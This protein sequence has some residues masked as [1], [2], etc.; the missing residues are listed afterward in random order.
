MREWKYI[1]LHI[2]NTDAHVVVAQPHVTAALSYEKNSLLSQDTRL[3]G[4]NTRS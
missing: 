4:H 1:S 2:L 3:C